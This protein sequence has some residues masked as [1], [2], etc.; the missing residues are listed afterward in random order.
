MDLSRLTQN[1]TETC[2]AVNTL[3]YTQNDDFNTHDMIIGLLS[4][5]L[6]NNTYLCRTHAGS[7]GSVCEWVCE[8]VSVDVFD[9]TFTS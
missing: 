4:K 1:E 2:L 3:T 6:N 7:A 8:I 5:Q 9:D